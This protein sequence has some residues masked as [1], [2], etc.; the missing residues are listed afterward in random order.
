M[1]TGAFWRWDIR[2]YK[3]KKKKKPSIIHLPCLLE[4]SFMHLH[5]FLKGMLLYTASTTVDEHPAY[6]WISQI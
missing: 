6:I 3:M 1:E 4:K 2:P 5:I